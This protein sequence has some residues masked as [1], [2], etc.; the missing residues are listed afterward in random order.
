[1]N[2]LDLMEK[3]RAETPSADPAI[4]RRAR[5]AMF[6]PGKK[7]RSRLVWRLAPAAAL[8]AVA[9]VTVVAVR[10]GEPA[11]PPP[12]ATGPQDVPASAGTAPAD[13]GTVLRLAAAEARREPA[14][15]ARDDQF[16]Y[17]E[18]Q[19]AWAG[20][21]VGKDN[22]KYLPPVPKVRRIWLSVN[23]TR[24]GL[25]REKLTA[26]GGKTATYPLPVHQEG[27]AYAPWPGFLDDLPTTTKAMRAYLYRGDPGD[28]PADMVA[29]SMV[30]DLLRERY[31]PPKSVA[32]LFDAAAT[33]P[34]TKVVHQADSAGRKGTAVSRTDNGMRHDLIFDAKT[35]RFLGER[36]VA[37]GDVRPF[38]KG[39][40][41]GFTA[42]MKVAIVDAAGQLP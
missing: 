34:G 19:V 2:D 33:I 21:R 7:D 16:V 23:G 27:G 8:A 42:Q 32:T 4:L 31:V 30:G 18:S 14:L 5:A 36:D 38:P 24:D 39:A 1:M 20:A 13:A 37:V 22:V 15:P 9:A 29:W 6:P 11:A 10:S 25:L 26:A 12:A 17:V 28:R 3:F 40:V 35:Y 41:T